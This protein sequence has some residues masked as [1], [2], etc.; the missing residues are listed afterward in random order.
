MQNG[1][2]TGEVDPPPAETDHW[3][4]LMALAQA[5]DAAAYRRLLTELLPYLRRA[6]A[7]SVRDRDE[8]EDVVQDILL[9]LHRVRATFDPAR[10]FRPWLIG[11]AR[12]RII[13]RHRH[14][15]RIAANEVMIDF[16]D[17]TNS[18]L[19][20]NGS[21]EDMSLHQVQAAVERLSVGQRRAFEAVRVRG[22][23][24]KE[25][26]VETGMSVGA[27]K[28]AVHRAIRTLRATLLGSSDR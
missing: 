18:A 1:V 22:L 16:A 15:M 28:V 13:D 7:R 8:A 23:S 17:E 12:R 9:T 25:A 3:A 11:I 10:P 19:A 4:V 27:L 21:H 5:G 24:L 2:R 20:A 14:R 6:V 26:A